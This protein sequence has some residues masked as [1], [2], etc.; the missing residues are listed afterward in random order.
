MSASPS[1]R[2]LA[3]MLSVLVLA[4]SPSVLAQAGKAPPAKPQTGDTE[5]PKPVDTSDDPAAAAAEPEG[6]EF[7]VPAPAATTTTEAEEEDTRPKDLFYGM[8]ARMRWVSIPKWMLNLFTEENQSLSSYHAGVEFFRRRTD[9]DFILGLSFQKMSPG[10]GNW[11]GKGEDP[12]EKTDFVQFRDFNMISLDGAFVWRQT[13]SPY[14]GIH[15]GA[16]IGV[17]L[18][19]GK[20]L[21]TSSTG[22]TSTN[23]GDLTMCRPL[24]VTCN[25]GGCSEKDLADT[26]VKGGKAVDEPG[27]PSRY[28]DGNVPPVIPIVNVLGGIDV[29]H[30]DIKGLNLRIEGGFF[31]AFFLGGAL[32]YAF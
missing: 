15:Y 8:G 1:A 32:M 12:A 31:N 16:G 22:C 5:Q 7:A 6:S 19:T 17:A 24:G 11:L 14:F 25:A 26:E 2:P 13:F 21:R 23:L 29:M 27:D 20:I 9:M 10:D 3:A 18:V 30:P 4:A 28:K